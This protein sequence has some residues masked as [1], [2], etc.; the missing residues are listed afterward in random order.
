VISEAF[1]CGTYLNVMHCT[2]TL[3]M[4]R[5]HTCA[6]IFVVVDLVVS[7]PRKSIIKC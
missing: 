5:G 2:C 3:Q 1:I 7:F 6:I 4:N